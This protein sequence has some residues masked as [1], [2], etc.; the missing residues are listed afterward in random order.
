MAGKRKRKLVG[1]REDLSKRTVSRQQ[2][3]GFTKHAGPMRATVRDGSDFGSAAI[4]KIID[5]L[6]LNPNTLVKR[7]RRADPL[8]QLD[9]P[10][11]LAQAAIVYRQAVQHIAAGIGMGP[12]PWAREREHGGSSGVAVELLPQERALSAADCHRKGVQA[13]GMAAAEGVVHWVVIAERPLADYDATR[14]WRKGR[15]MAELIAALERLAMALG[16]A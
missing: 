5:D 8:V 9:L 15:G 4:P 10:G 14:K 6:H 3:G 7:A 11:S 16:I 13:M 1:Q 2:H 12:M